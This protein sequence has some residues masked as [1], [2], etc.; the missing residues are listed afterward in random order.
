MSKQKT[1]QS[2]QTEIYISLIFDEKQLSQQA[3]VDLILHNMK[4]GNQK[5]GL[6][7]APITRYNKDK[8]FSDVR[9]G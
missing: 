3:F 8:V 2:K 9:V 7:P 5:S 1:K 6:E 4:H